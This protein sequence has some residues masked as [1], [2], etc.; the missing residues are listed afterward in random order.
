MYNYEKKY[1]SK[2]EYIL[3]GSTYEGYVGIRNNNAY[4]Y[5]TNEILE[6]NKSFGAQFNSGKNFFDRILDEDLRLPYS[7]KEIQYQ[8]NDFLHKNTLKTIVKNLSMNNDYIFKCSTIGNTTL[9]VN[10][11]CIIYTPSLEEKGNLEGNFLNSKEFTTKIHNFDNITA[12]DMCVVDVEMIDNEKRVTIL[13]FF[14]YNNE[15]KVIKHYYYPE[16]PDKSKDIPLELNNALII[17]KIDINK[18]NSIEYLDIKA[19]KVKGNYLYVVDEKL[20]MVV[21]YDIE[22]LRTSWVD[23]DENKKNIRVIDIVQGEGTVED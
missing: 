20:H 14:A 7:K 17:N 1:W 5:D 16:N 19:I 4:I 8:N 9:P 23:G 12:S 21:R 6:K 15:I 3:N 11:K 13:L 18:R 10:E 22:F 2:D